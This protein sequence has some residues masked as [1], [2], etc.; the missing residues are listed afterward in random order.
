[1]PTQLQLASQV[2]PTVLM[3]PSSPGGAGQKPRCHRARPGSHQA[4]GAVAVGIQV[5]PRCSGRHR[6]RRCR[7]G[8]AAGHAQAVVHRPPVRLQLASQVSPVVFGSPSS[9]AVPGGA[10]PPARLGSRPQPP[11]QLQLASR[12]VRVAIVAGGAGRNAAAGRPGSRPT[13]PPVRICQLASQVSPEVSGRHRRRR[14][15]AET[16]PPGNAQAVVHQAAGAVAVGIPGLTCGVRVAIVAGG[17]GQGRCRR[18]RPG[19]HPPGRR[20]QFPRPFRRRQLPQALPPGIPGRPP[21]AG[22]VAVGIGLTRWCSG[23]ASSR[24][25]CRAGASPGTPNDRPPDRRCSCS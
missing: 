22:A 11:V 6:R 16:P 3:S 1:M 23:R 13:R 12:G 5:S 10:L 19:S 4:A 18:A 14:C 7:A 9:Q 20:C 17:A 8:A 21:G 2:S 25:R 15:Q 24:R